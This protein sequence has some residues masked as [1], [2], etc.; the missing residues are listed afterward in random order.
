VSLGEAVKDLAVALEQFLG[1]GSEVVVGADP[2]DLRRECVDDELVDAVTAHSG[3]GLCVIG[4]IV[5]QPDGGLL[6]HDITMRFGELLQFTSAYR[7]RCGATSGE[8]EPS[9]RT[10]SYQP[11]E[12]SQ[13]GVRDEHHASVRRPVDVPLAD[14][15]ALCA[16]LAPEP[17]RLRQFRARPIRRSPSFELP[18]VGP[19]Q[20]HDTLAG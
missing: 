11:N 12:T 13:V 15:P 4:E 3:H 19:V 7:R 6:C 18:R 17:V 14:G 8:R 20:R 5:G 10:D 9:S 2:F 1:A 16:L